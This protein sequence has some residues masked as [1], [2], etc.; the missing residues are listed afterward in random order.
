LETFTTVGYGDIYPQNYIEVSYLLFL[1][2]IG[3]TGF[4]YIMGTIGSIMTCIDIQE[5]EKA[6]KMFNF[7]K[8]EKKKFVPRPLLH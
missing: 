1:E 8:L 5:A 2:L 4:S 6:T 3:V 7:R